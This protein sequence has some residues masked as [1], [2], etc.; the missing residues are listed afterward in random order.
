MSL[1]QR[2][3]ILRMIEQLAE[4]IGRIAGLRRAGELAEAH[5]VLRETADGLFGPMR[6]MLD[7]VDAA[8]AATLLGD[9]EKIGAYAALCAEQAAILEAQ[10]RG[11]QAAAE[12]LRA[13]ELHLEA[14]RRAPEDNPRAREGARALLGQ[15]DVTRLP[16]RYRALA[17]ELG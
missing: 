8:G 7:R 5:R 2:D 6:D 14:V 9:H 12:R 13:L 4:A 3:Y 11:A 10:G 17:A 1:R 15:V 16:D